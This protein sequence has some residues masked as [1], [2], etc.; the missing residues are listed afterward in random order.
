MDKLRVLIVD[1]EEI[2]I[3]GL[4]AL[5]SERWPDFEVRHAENGQLALSMSKSFQPD[6]VITDVRMP[7]TDGL[8][9]EE[10]T[11]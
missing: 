6:L 5:L 8:R 11:S 7:L 9:S 4:R 2:V 3:R 10:H 1:D